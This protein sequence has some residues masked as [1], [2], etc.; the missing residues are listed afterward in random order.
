[1]HAIIPLSILN[2]EKSFSC[3][4]PKM[5]HRQSLFISIINLVACLG[6]VVRDSVQRADKFWAWDSPAVLRFS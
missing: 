6:A 1:M 5:V 2:I 4:I 3:S